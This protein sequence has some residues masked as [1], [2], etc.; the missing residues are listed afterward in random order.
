MEYVETANLIN[1]GLL[2][3]IAILA[4]ILIP[5]LIGIWNLT[6][7]KTAAAALTHNHGSSVA[8]AIARQEASINRIEANATVQGE[9]LAALTHMVESH[10]A[11]DLPWPGQSSN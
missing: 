5:S 1:N 10:I 3:D 6:H 7:T 8:D 4:S 2:R 11:T 9:Q